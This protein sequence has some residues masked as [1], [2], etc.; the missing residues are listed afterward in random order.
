MTTE[1]ER[2]L[3]TRQAIRREYGE[4]YDRVP[5]MFFEADPIGINFGDNADEYEPEVDTIL[6]RAMVHGTRWVGQ[7][8]S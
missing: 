8:D 4:L 1:R 7:V 5:Q 2:L 3:A 6:P